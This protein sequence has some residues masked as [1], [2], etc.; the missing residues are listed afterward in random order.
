MSDFEEVGLSCGRCLEACKEWE[1]EFLYCIKCQNYV[2]LTCLAN[3]RVPGDLLG[4]VF[5][6]YICYDCTDDGTEVFRRTNIP[7]LEAV[8]LALQNL[9]THRPNL[10]RKG[11]FHYKAH[12]A[13]FLEKKSSTIFGNNL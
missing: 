3:G 5:F 4:D 10:A 11:Y 9:H 8:V 1:E 7:W 13:A 6:S 2:H 12:I